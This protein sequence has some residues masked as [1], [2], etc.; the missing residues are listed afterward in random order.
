MKTARMQVAKIISDKIEGG[1]AFKHLA[2]EIAAYLL[3]ERRVHELDSLMRDVIQYRALIGINEI[4]LIS[5]HEL[6]SNLKTEI[7]QY[8]NE[9]DLK[10]K[11]VVLN[12]RINKD[13][14]GG[15][16]IE[17]N[18]SKILDLSVRAK[19]NNFKQLISQGKV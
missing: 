6:D 4:D 2:Q 7:Q 16:R 18:A 5:A 1:V 15:L 3:A 9:T 12:S 11:T 8:L 10:S 13:L 19:F 14:I 17:I